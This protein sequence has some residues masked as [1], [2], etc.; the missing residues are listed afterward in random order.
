MALEDSRPRRSAVLRRWERRLSGKAKSYPSVG[1][2]EKKSVYASSEHR[3]SGEACEERQRT[4][5]G[6]ALR[7]RLEGRGCAAS[8]HGRDCNFAGREAKPKG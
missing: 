5:D 2:A 4:G 1:I 6:S 3:E 8:W 7:G